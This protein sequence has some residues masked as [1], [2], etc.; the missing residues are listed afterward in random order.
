MVEKTI[1]V[2][3][4]GNALGAYQAGAYE[5]LSSAGVE[6]HRIVAASAGAV[7]AAIIAGNPPERRVENLRRFWDEAARH[8][9]PW[10]MGASVW[11]DDRARVFHSILFGSPTIFRPRLPGALSMLPGM[12]GDASLYDL[13]PLRATLER[14]ID[15]GRLNAGDPHLTVVAVDLMTGE[16]VRFD[17]REAPIGADHLVASSSFP[18]FFPPV[19][20]GGRLLCDGGMGANLP[21]AAALE[22][23]SEEDRL[24]IAID[25]FCR[26]GERPRTVG[27][28]TDRQLELL[29]TA[30]TWAAVDALR[31][32]HA[33]RRHLRTLAE[34][35]PAARRADAEVVA[36]MAD[37]ATGAD[38]GITLLLLSHR[39]VA[40]D[41][42]MR[43]FDFSRPVLA[44]RWHAG[45]A[46]MAHSLGTLGTR[47]AGS[48]EFI[49]HA[50]GMGDGPEMT[51]CRDGGAGSADHATASG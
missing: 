42:E 10:A 5:A 41:V 4:G 15:F 26:R 49:V 24:C 40:H 38:G 11:G 50:A 32:T 25:L 21:I 13:T 22:D 35:L 7:N 30:Q 27:Q 44:E 19:G 9:P 18:P 37:A 17:T 48:G 29:L 47:R 12:P 36:A 51:Q 8:D 20:I 45:R 16:E 34:R 31:R 3:S 14:V 39:P 33:L 46:E 43:A 28:A 23:R 6:P 2:L 1:L